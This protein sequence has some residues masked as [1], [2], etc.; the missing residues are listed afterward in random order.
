[1]NAIRLGFQK[2]KAYFNS[3]NDLKGPAVKN[4]LPELPLSRQNI[5]LVLKNN[6]IEDPF[7]LKSNLTEVKHVVHQE[8]SVTDVASTSTIRTYFALQPLQ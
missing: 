4:E 2:E 7:A 6:T 5:K 3:E 1:M 8:S